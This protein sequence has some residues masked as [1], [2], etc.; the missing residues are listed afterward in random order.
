MNT[1]VLLA[2]IVI[3]VCTISLA[4]RIINATAQDI[5][6][7]QGERKMLEWRVMQQRLA[8]GGEYNASEGWK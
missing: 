7:E 6:R 4:I 5:A 3:V 2:L 8:K 1:M